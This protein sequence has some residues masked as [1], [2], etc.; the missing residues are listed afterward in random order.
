M[1]NEPCRTQSV[2]M[3]EEQAEHLN[4]DQLDLIA[5]IERHLRA[6][7]LTMRRIG[8]LR[9]ARHRVGPE[10][11]DGERCAALTGLAD[12]IGVIETNLEL[13]EDSCREMHAIVSL[14]G[15]GASPHP[16]RSGTLGYHSPRD[17]WSVPYLP[18][19]SV[20]SRRVAG[21]L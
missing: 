18:G 17:H 13:Q 4:A 15:C 14:P 12:E 3:L 8:T 10:L 16:R 19:L 6:V 21:S 7:Q 20:P 5:Q 11:S 2:H 9:D 1:A